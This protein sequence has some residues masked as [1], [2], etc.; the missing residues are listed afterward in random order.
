MCFHQLVENH[1]N[2]WSSWGLNIR[3]F[4]NVKMIAFYIELNIK[5]INDATNG[6][7]KDNILM[8]K[9]LHF[10]IRCYETCKIHLDFNNFF[11][12]IQIHNL[13]N[14]SLGTRVNIV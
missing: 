12:E 4:M 6:N 5:I 1:I 11:I 9:A 8:Y 10:H 13:C 7:R 2:C 3:K 14:G